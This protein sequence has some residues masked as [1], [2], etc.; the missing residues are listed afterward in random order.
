M[1]TWWLPV[2][3]KVFVANISKEQQQGSV[4]TSNETIEHNMPFACEL[5]MYYGQVWIL[6]LKMALA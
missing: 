3:T 5:C 4:S 1:L 6:D 2:S